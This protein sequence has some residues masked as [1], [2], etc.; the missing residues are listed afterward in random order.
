M[1]KFMLAYVLFVAA[2]VGCG[3]GGGDPVPPANP[4][5][6]PGIE[7]LK[8]ASSGADDGSARQKIAE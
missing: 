3:G 5:P 6:P 2:L 4:D 1:R 8:G 7:G